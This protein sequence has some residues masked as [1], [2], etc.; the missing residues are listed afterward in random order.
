MLSSRLVRIASD[1]TREI[2]EFD[3]LGLMQSGISIASNRPNLNGQQYNTQRAKLIEQAERISAETVFRSYPLDLLNVISQ[4]ELSSIL[5]GNLAKL[6]I[7][8]FPHDKE[9]GIS[10]A[11]LQ[12]YANQARTALSQIS[13]LITFANRMGVR[14]YE[15]PKDK[16]ALDLKFPRSVFHNSIGP[17]SEKLSNFN[18]FMKS[19]TEL[20]TGSRHEIQLLYISTTDP[21]IAGTFIPAAAWA[22]LKFYKLF[23]EVAEKQINVWKAIR[24]LRNSGLTQEKTKSI[25][26]DMREDIRLEI[27]KAVDEGMKAISSKLDVGRQ[28]EIKIE[29]TKKAAEITADIASGTRIYVS[30]ESQ[31]DL[32]MIS[33][34]VLEASISET[35]IQ[36]QL[37][38]QKALEAKLDSLGL[39]ENIP[40]LLTSRQEEISARRAD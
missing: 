1:I 17:F 26:E 16:L 34:S 33:S 40:E 27:A 18:Q 6:I 9:A 30:L 20:A 5:P 8:G 35:E 28:N 15:P 32:A 31:Q 37:D 7:A 3:V 29:I 25:E 36:A 22:I 10:S 24:D 12:M 19:V 4:S 14:A 11:E 39:T 23:L 13:G 38:E 21:I 2:N